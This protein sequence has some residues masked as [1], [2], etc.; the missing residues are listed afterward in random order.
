LS[1]GILTLLIKKEII[2]IWGDPKPR[3]ENPAP[4]K[5]TATS[6]G[7]LT[8]TTYHISFMPASYYLYSDKL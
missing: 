5:F 2:S 6:Y 1:S 8:G 7:L 3:R 4:L